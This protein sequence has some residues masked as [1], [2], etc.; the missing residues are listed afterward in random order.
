MGSPIPPQAEEGE[1]RGGEMSDIGNEYFSDEELFAAKQQFRNSDRIHALI[2]R[3]EAAEEYAK[4]HICK[5]KGTHGA[6]DIYQIGCQHKI[7]WLK[8]KG[9]AV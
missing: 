2:S 5:F 3:L 1:E 9:E 7:R 8:S 6:T 4:N